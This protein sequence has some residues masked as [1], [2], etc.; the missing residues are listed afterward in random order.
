MTRPICSTGSR[1]RRS[2]RAA[3]TTARNST[4][5]DGGSIGWVTRVAAVELGTNSTRLLSGHEE[6]LLTFRGVTADRGLSEGTV[7]VDPGGGSTE[8][9][10]AASDGVRWHESLDIGSARLTERFLHSD[11]PSA[12]ELA[13]CAAAV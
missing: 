1:R 2:V 7:I 4:Q 3:A 8:F 5:S 13:A 9:V 10:V 12:D 6:A 11:P